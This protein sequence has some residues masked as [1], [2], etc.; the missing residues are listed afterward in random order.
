MTFKDFIYKCENYEYSNDY[1]DI[2]KESSEALLI[3]FI[4]AFV[5]HVV[6]LTGTHDGSQ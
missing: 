5:A 4:P 6:P 2:M 1:Y 3:Y